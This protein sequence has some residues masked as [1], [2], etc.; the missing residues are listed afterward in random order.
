MNR[1]VYTTANVKQAIKFLK[2]SDTTPPTFMKRYKGTTKNGKLYLDGKRVVQ[3]EQ[4]A[5]YLRTLVLGGKVPL[6][7]DS[8]FYF[9]S[10]SVV[11][12]SRDAVEKFLKSQHIIRET[13]NRQNKIKHASRAVKKKGQLSY[14]LI[15]INWLDLGFLP[16]DKNIEKDSGYIFACVDA[17][18]SLSY[19]EFSL[20]KKQ[21]DITPIAKRCFEWFAKHLNIPMNKL[22][23][24]SDKGNEFSFKTYNDWGVRTIQ[25]RRANIIEARNSFF[26]RVLYRTAKMNQTRNLKELVKNAMAITNRTQSSVTKKT[27]IENLK[28][29]LDTLQKKYNK[30]R[31]KDSGQKIK[32]KPL[33][34]GDK[35][36]YD[37]IGPKQTSFYKAY[38]A[39]TWSTKAYPVIGKKGSRYKIDLGAKGKK[40]YGRDE[41]R[42]TVTADKKTSKILAKRRVALYTKGIKG[43]A[44]FQQKLKE[45]AYLKKLKEKYGTTRSIAAANKA[46]KKIEK[47]FSDW[48]K[49]KL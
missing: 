4:V 29:P 15:E 3:T 17:L 22:V 14:D 23:G 35:V 11:G 43:E 9:I 32:M 49:D 6:A 39:D 33:Q 42:L 25:L 40:F 19:F 24:Y 26:Q 38:K 8:L 41:L 31:G 12:V 20:S 30:K 27:P 45:Q 16:S 34:I 44:L 36:R 5:T 46:N 10:R 28:E 1:Y 21:K 2:D 47:L 37:L 18:T 7:R 48:K 13:D